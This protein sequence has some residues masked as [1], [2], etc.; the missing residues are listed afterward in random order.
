[1]K[2]LRVGVVGLRN[3]G[4][5]HVEALLGLAGFQLSALCDVDLGQVADLRRRFAI[6]SEHVREFSEYREM[7]AARCIDAAI[8]ALPHDLHADA[9]KAAAAHGIHVLKEKPL[10]R[11]LQEAHELAEAMRSAGVVLYTGVQRRRHPTYKRLAE[12]LHESTRS[13]HVI[14]AAIKISVVGKAGARHDWRRDIGRAGGGVLIDLGYHGVDLAQM[15]LGPLS[16]VSCTLFSGNVPSAA[17][18]IETAASVWARAGAAWVHLD[19]RRSDTKNE[20][21]RV[22]CSDGTYEADRVSLSFQ[23]N[24]G[25]CIVLHQCE[26]GWLPTLKNQLTEFQAAVC[27]GASGSDDLESHLPALRFLDACYAQHVNEGIVISRSDA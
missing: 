7:F 8:I 22:E 16:L 12:V 15:L 11:N 24:G 26:S 23:P 21:V 17:R 1:M 14:S 25:K 4:A 13:S 27:Q 9:V 2:T 10:G 3:Q 6:D 5:E 19:F 18:T 20:K